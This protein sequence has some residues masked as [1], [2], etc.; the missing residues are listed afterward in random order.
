MKQD[1]ARAIHEEADRLIRGMYDGQVPWTARERARERKLSAAFATARPDEQATAA[2]YRLVYG[3]PARLATIEPISPGLGPQAGNTGIDALLHFARFSD[4][5]QRTPEEWTP[6]GK[7]S[8]TLVASLARH[9]FARYPLPAF[10]DASWLSGF[11][12]Q[13]ESYREWFVHLGSG[14]RLE[15]L[16]FPMPM[17]H[18]AAHHFLLALD[19]FTIPAALRYG[20]IRAIGGREALAW[21]VSETFLSNLQPDEPFWLSVLHFLV[22]HPE[23]PMHQVGP[24]LDYLRF[25][26]F[27]TGG[28][29]GPEPSLSMK[30][31]TSTALLARMEEWHETLARLGK[32]SR[33]SWEPS[34]IRSLERTEPDSLSAA[35]C[36][37]RILEL[38]DSLSLLEEGREMRHCV[39]SYQDG[40][41]KGEKS[42]WSLRL[43]LS[44][45]PRAP[46]RLLTIEV[47]H[48]RRSIVQVRGKCN[49][50]LSAMRG[51]HRMML[52]RDLL[53]AWAHERHLGIACAL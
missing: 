50:T 25:R 27:G 14:G 33:Q 53:R 51:N 29:D 22:N 47:N 44:D 9:L 18:R 12:T 26:K 24:I 17:T 30:G 2:L 5:W 4:R 21:N 28:D 42:I 10:L 23:I 49:Q 40:C 32:K 8:H 46:R 43:T 35:T 3:A 48:N 45:N 37:W 38:T 52:A 19:H 31:R 41:V 34:G 16:A 11:D 15:S 39:R 1:E 36:H 13:A 6:D 7:D 20:Q